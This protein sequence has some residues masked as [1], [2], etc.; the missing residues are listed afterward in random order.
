MSVPPAAAAAAAIDGIVARMGTPRAPKVRKVLR[1]PIASETDGQ[2]RRPP[3]LASDM[4]ATNEP[5]KA[6]ST[7]S[8]YA[9]E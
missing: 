7:R 8:G 9:G 5:A 1:R 4:P 3:R 6:P 2:K